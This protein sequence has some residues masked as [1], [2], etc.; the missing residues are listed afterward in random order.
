MIKVAP[1]ERSLLLVYNAD[2]GFFNALT[3]SAHKMFS[4]S[5]Y[6]CRLCALTY[7]AVQMHL[8]WAV[9]LRSLPLSVSFLHRDEFRSQ[10]ATVKTD[11]PAVFLVSR[12]RTHLLIGAAEIK[13]CKSLKDLEELLQSQAYEATGY[14]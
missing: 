6:E 2:S 12:A 11:L 4:P 13:Q 9:F 3:D 7:G 10:F 5:T 1:P 14:P 8:E